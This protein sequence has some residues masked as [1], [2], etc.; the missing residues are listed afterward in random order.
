VT[1]RWIGKEASFVADLLLAA[2]AKDPDADVRAAAAR[3]VHAV[4][5]KPETAIELLVKALGDLSP[6]VRRAAVEVLGLYGMAAFSAERPLVE[7]LKAGELRPQVVST[8]GG[9]G[10]LEGETISVLMDLLAGDSAGKLFDRIARALRGCGVRAKDAVPIL[11]RVLKSNRRG[12]NAVSAM[13]LLEALGPAAKEAVPVLL[14]RLTTGGRTDRSAA[15]RALGAM[16]DLRAVPAL[17]K[18]RG[19]ALGAALVA[20][21]RLRAPQRSRP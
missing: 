10:Y 7:M 19:W 2:L 5:V 15:A 1:A 3:A 11:I 6:D 14:Q 20:L 12:G 17:E 16:G 21:D 9:I 13:Q 4:G 8:L 18:A